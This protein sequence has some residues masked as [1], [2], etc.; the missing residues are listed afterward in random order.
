MQLGKSAA[1]RR[2]YTVCNQPKSKSNV[3]ERTEDR[4]SKSNS[5]NFADTQITRS[6]VFIFKI[7]RAVN[8]R[9]KEFRKTQNEQEYRR[10]GKWR[11]EV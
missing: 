1:F 6:N 2:E 5:L 9:M 11:V 3:L 10:G 8:S 4:E 7:K